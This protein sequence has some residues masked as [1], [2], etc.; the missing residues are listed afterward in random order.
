VLGFAGLVGS[1]LGLGSYL[2]HAR[3]PAGGFR[4]FL[5]FAIANLVGSLIAILPQRDHIFEY[6][7]DLLMGCA[8]AWPLPLLLACVPRREPPAPIARVV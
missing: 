2:A 5:M 8:V 7:L 4:A 1:G 3:H 6:E